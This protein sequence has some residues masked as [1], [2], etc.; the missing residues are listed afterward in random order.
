MSLTTH[1]SGLMANAQVGK[2]IAALEVSPCID[3]L[4]LLLV[5]FPRSA[6]LELWLGTK[7]D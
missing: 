5:S 4:E 2:K 1:K 6:I 3:I 7:L